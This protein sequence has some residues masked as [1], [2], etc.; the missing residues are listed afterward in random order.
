VLA[1]ATGQIQE[2][3]TELPTDE[4]WKQVNDLLTR[5]LTIQ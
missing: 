3:F 4:S 2:L 1:T 5:L